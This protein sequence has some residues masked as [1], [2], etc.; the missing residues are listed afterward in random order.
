MSPFFV[1]ASMLAPRARSA[2]RIDSGRS[3][4]S[5]CDS[6]LCFKAVKTV[7]FEQT[8]SAVFLKWIT[9]LYYLMITLL[10]CKHQRCVPS[11]IFCFNVRPM[12]E[13]CLQDKCSSLHYVHFLSAYIHIYI[14]FK[15]INKTVLD[16]CHLLR[17]YK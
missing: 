7:N 4:A 10:E 5:E 1:F 9:Y 17:I 12:I 16:N 6:H 3:I 2:C 13:Q 8:R 11:F 14:Y 15:T